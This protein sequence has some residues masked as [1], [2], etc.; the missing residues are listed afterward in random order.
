MPLHQDEVT[1][2]TG[3]DETDSGKVRG[4]SLEPVSID[5][6]LQVVNPQ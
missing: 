4:I 6:S 5:V 1:V 3:N 2:S